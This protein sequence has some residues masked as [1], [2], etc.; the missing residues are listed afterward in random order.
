[1]V[2]KFFFQRLWKDLEHA[3]KNK[4]RNHLDVVERLLL[5]VPSDLMEISNAFV[6]ET[7]TREVLKAVVDCGFRPSYLSYGPLM[8]VLECGENS[9]I[10]EHLTSD[11]I[12]VNTPWDKMDSIWFKSVL[13]NSMPTLK[14]SVHCDALPAN[15]SSGVQQC[16][17][18]KIDELIIGFNHTRH[19]SHILSK[20][21]RSVLLSHCS[22][23]RHLEISGFHPSHMGFRAVERV[24]VLSSSS[25]LEWLLQQPH[26]TCLKLSGVISTIEAKSLILT[27]LSTP[28]TSQQRLE[29]SNVVS[30]TEPENAVQSLPLNNSYYPRKCLLIDNVCMVHA[31]KFSL[32]KYQLSKD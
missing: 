9:A 17:N 32:N 16:G 19:E 12:G 22:H 5:G 3:E 29:L 6:A 11:V 15:I 1:M 24:T 14:L 21:T 7:V 30:E 10:M 27:F 28:C 13:S 2:E 4:T 25:P 23:L 18:K 26:F 8:D 31:R 20:L